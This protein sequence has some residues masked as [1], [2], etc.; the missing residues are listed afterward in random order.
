MYHLKSLFAILISLQYLIR[1]LA[2]RAYLKNI[3]AHNILRWHTFCKT[4][5][6]NFVYSTDAQQ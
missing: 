4:N 1:K 2:A 6:E 5:P 3:A